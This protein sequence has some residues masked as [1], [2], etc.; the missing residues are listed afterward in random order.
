MLQSTVIIVSYVTNKQTNQPTWSGDDDVRLLCKC[1]GL[2]N[3][4]NPSD[5]ACGTERDRCPEGFEYFI[6]LKS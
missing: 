3:H 4:V 2:S 1:D 5:D 6:D